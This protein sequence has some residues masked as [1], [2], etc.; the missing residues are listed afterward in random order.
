MCRFCYA[1]LEAPQ[2]GN[3]DDNSDGNS[4]Y[5][6]PLLDDDPQSSSP[7]IGTYYGPRGDRF[8]PALHDNHP[9]L[10]EFLMLLLMR[11]GFSLILEGLSRASEPHHI[12]STEPLCSGIALIF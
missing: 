5:C 6:A 10:A 2:F 7:E 9:C 11:E 1:D 12:L 4:E 3:R 8:V